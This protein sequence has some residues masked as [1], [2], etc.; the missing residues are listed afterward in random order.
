[1]LCFM[2]QVTSTK[3]QEILAA[4]AAAVE[5]FTGAAAAQSP[6]ELLQNGGLQEKSG[7]LQSPFQAVRLR[8]EIRFA[9]LA[10]EPGLRGEQL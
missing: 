8:T 7:R 9:R 6:P 2:A 4:A 1:M 10:A 3:A 5:G